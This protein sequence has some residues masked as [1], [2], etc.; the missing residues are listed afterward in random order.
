MGLTLTTLGCYSRNAHFIKH[1]YDSYP[2]KPDDHEI[3]VF[4]QGEVPD[5]EYVVIGLV[6]VDSQSGRIFSGMITEE[7]ILEFLK[8]EARRHGADAIMAIQIQKDVELVSDADITGVE[9]TK[10]SEAKAIVFR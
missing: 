5:R 2:A 8:K 3:M 10:R 7:K 1:G 6:V 4:D 9:L